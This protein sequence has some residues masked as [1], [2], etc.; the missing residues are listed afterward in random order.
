[1]GMHGLICGSAFLSGL[2]KA[3]YG[4]RM[5]CEVPCKL[6]FTENRGSLNYCSVG[7][8]STQRPN[9]RQRSQLFSVCIWY[10]L[11]SR[12]RSYNS[13]RGGKGGEGFANVLV[14][15]ERLTGKRMFCDIV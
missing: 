12:C 6:S 2:T 7:F 11:T 13:F 9:E 14:F 5:I 3:V 1:M 4:N 8:H 10:M 15:I